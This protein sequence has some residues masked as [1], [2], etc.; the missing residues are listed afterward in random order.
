M[1]LSFWI[2]GVDPGFVIS[3]D[4]CGKVF[5]LSDMFQEIF[6]DSQPTLPRSCVSRWST[7]LRTICFD[8]FLTEETFQI[9]CILLITLSP[10]ARISI[11]WVCFAAI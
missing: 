6:A 3:D 4:D 7:N 9:L 11:L 10:N 5:I 8:H 2:K 1:L